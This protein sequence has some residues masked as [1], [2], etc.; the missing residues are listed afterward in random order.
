MNKKKIIIL[1]VLIII[2]LMIIEGLVFWLGFSQKNTIEGQNSKVAKLYNELQE[3]QT[4]SFTTTLNDEN[5]VFYAKKDNKAFIKTI[6]QGN[7]T[8]F[9]IKDGNSYL[10]LDDEKVYYTYQNN[11]TDLEKIS[12]E[13]GEIKEKQY[14]EGKEKIENKEYKYEEYE[15]VTKFLIKD[16]ADYEI[17]NAKTR[18]YFNGD[19]LVYIKT[20]V[21]EYQEILEVDIS[22]SVDKE[23]FEIPADYKEM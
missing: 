16:I 17:V 15:G 6:Y 20:I 13:L 2:F 9:L 5:L 22:S 4:Y 1:S 18:F 3:K 23:L 8:K 12:A 11:E 7:E 10:L 19:K 21:G 14:T